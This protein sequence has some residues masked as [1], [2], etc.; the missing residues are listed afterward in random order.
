MSSSIVLIAIPLRNMTSAYSYKAHVTF[1]QLDWS[2]NDG[3]T[4]KICIYTPTI[5]NHANI[6]YIQGIV[7]NISKPLTSAS[8]LVAG[9]SATSSFSKHGGL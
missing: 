8:A 3:G 4:Y 1:F 5:G 7:D 2:V 9:T 6:R